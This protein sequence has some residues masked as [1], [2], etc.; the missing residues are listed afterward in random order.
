MR[1]RRDA[2]LERNARDAAEGLVVIQYFLRN[3]FGVADEQRARGP[4][5]GVELRPG[6]RRPAALP[7]D[8]GERVRVAWIEVVG[9]LLCGVGQKT[10]G[11]KSHGQ[12][13]GGGA[14]R[15]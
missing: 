13:L 5:D 14:G 9:S 2:H 12:L 15:G 10:D 7:A 6:G 11:V 1:N 3:S 8:F 4:A